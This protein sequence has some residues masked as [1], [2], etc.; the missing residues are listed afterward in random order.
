ML[1]EDTRKSNSEVR[2]LATTGRKKPEATLADIAGE[3]E[4]C[5]DEDEETDRLHAGAMTRES[6]TAGLGRK[7]DSLR[8][9]GIPN[10]PIKAEQSDYGDK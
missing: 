6:G 4:Q 1:A 7:R 2:V 9:P 8:C 10:R 3:N 5:F